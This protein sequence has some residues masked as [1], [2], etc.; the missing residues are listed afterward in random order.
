MTERQQRLRN[1]CV[2][3]FTHAHHYIAPHGWTKSH[4]D[5]IPLRFLQKARHCCQAGMGIESHCTYSPTIQTNRG[6]AAVQLTTGYNVGPERGVPHSSAPPLPH[7]RL[8]KPH[9]A[10][11]PERAC[12]SSFDG[13]KRQLTDQRFFKPKEMCHHQRTAACGHLGQ[14]CHRAPPEQPK[15]AAQRP[16]KM[17]GI[18]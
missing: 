18:P 6:N 17:P 4:G 1:K 12:P 15:A 5:C 11:T 2:L 7:S 9:H 13:V 16:W 14:F 3:C 10:A 8:T